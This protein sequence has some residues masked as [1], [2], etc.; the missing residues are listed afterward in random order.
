LIINCNADGGQE[1]YHLHCICSAVGRSG[2]W[3]RELKFQEKEES[4]EEK[5]GAP[6]SPRRPRVRR[7]S[8]PANLP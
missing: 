7:R 6:A 3:F 5:K 4:D 1:V 2:P 8:S